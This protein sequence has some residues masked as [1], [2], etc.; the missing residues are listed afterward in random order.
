MHVQL[1]IQQNFV[2]PNWQLSTMTFAWSTADN[3]LYFE[4]RK[5]SCWSLSY[6]FN[7]SLIVLSFN[8]G[9]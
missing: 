2:K 9:I 8:L 6:C 7:L 1:Y 3:V 5:P 4:K